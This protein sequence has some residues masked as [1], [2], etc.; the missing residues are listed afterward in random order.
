[1]SSFGKRQPRC[2]FLSPKLDRYL[3]NRTTSCC[4]KHARAELDRLFSVIYL[5]FMPDALPW[6]MRLVLVSMD[7]VLTFW[8]KYLRTAG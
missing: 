3:D 8:G 4:G 7:C 2:P 1:V 6:R 5:C